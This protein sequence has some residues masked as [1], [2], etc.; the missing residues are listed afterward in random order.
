MPKIRTSRSKPPPAGYDLIEPTLTSLAL[1]MRAAEQQP[2]EGLRRNAS[3]Y[4]IIRIHHQRSLY[5]FDLYYK[6]KAISKEL[7][8]WCCKQ[9]HADVNLIAKWRKAGYEGLC[10]LQCVQTRDTDFGTTCVC[11]VPKSSLEEG[12]VIEC[13]R[14]G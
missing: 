4:P 13:V 2:D 3:L 14:C 8:D 11:R 7:Y 12:K 5:I 1:Q 9:G 6:R 10:C